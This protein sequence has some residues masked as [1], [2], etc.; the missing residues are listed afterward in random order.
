M[1]EN[2]GIQASVSGKKD[3]KTVNPPREGS[4]PTSNSDVDWKENKKKSSSLSNK[5]KDSGTEQGQKNWV[6]REL[7]SLPE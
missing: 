7:N 5:A 3:T 1:C 4:S 6:I 2:L